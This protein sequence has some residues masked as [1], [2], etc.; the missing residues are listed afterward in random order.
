MG[1][2]EGN[3]SQNGQKEQLVTVLDEIPIT[4]IKDDLGTTQTGQ[5]FKVLQFVG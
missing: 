3:T 4:E 5:F 1:A 2:N